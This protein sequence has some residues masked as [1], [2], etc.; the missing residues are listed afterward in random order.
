MLTDIL[1]RLQGEVALVE[2]ATAAERERIAH[3]ADI[4]GHKTFAQFLRAEPKCQ[5]PDC[6]GGQNGTHCRTV[7]HKPRADCRTVCH[8]PCPD[9]RDL[10]YDASGQVCA[11][12]FKED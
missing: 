11:C 12:Q 2:R 7:C 9:C 5:Y 3:L 10:G 6:A 1:R 4:W 8:K